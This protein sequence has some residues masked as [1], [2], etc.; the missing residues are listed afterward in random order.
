MICFCIALG[1]ALGAIALGI[2]IIPGYLIHLYLFL[3]T[4][5]WWCK[6]RVKKQ[7]KKKEE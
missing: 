7:Q 6:P 3:R 5:Y 4:L 2:G 1:A